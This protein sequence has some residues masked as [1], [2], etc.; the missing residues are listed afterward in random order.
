MKRI[1]HKKKR[2]ALELCAAAV[3]LAIAYWHILPFLTRAQ[4]I[5][6]RSHFPDPSFRRA[7]EEFMDVEPGESFTRQRAAAKAGTLTCT[8]RGTTDLTGIAFFPK[9]TGLDCQRTNLT[10]LDLSGNTEFRWL[11]VRSGKLTYL[12]LSG[13][14]A[15]RSVYLDGNPLAYLDLTGNAALQRL[16]A[17][18]CRLTS[19]DLT[20]CTALISL[21]VGFNK[22]PTVDL[23]ANT[24]LAR[25]DLR[26]NPLVA[27][28]DF[29]TLSQLKTVD[30]REC[31]GIFGDPDALQALRTQLGEPAFN[32]DRSYL[33][34]GLAVTEAE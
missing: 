22:L 28:P 24:Q 15:L 27:L 21:N 31:D 5:N 25:I 19:L 32:R 6:T 9:T 10:Y 34:T 4:S 11:N 29:S 33:M 16:D 18:N 26:G 23:S 8:G 12:D 2:L 1:F 13:N 20:N 14:T 17:R 30:L 3:V 7:A